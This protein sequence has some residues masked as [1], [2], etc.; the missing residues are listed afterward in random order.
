MP[1][2]KIFKKEQ[3]M[4]VGVTAA[5]KTWLIEDD[6]GNEVNEGD[7]LF[8]LRD[9]STIHVDA[10]EDYLLEKLDA[11]FAQILDWN[12]RTVSVVVFKNGTWIREDEIEDYFIEVLGAHVYERKTPLPKQK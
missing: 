4:V 1:S 11:K 10:A 9:G 3:P 6:F 8:T 2:E 5:N 7:Q 12:E